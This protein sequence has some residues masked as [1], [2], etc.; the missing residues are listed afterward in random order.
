MIAFKAAKRIKLDEQ[1]K[2]LMKENKI[3]VDEE[4]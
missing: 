2:E 3:E 1:N 4:M